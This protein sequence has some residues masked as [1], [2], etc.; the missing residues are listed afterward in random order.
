[1]KRIINRIKSE[2]TGLGFVV[3]LWK[4]EFDRIITEKQEA[5]TR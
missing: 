4:A 2:Y 1:M 3:F 5:I